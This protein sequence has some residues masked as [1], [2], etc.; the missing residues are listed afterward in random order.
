MLPPTPTNP[1]H[2]FPAPARCDTDQ[3]HSKEK[4]Q[5]TAASRPIKTSDKEK[6]T[7]STTAQPHQHQLRGR[8]PF[9]GDIMARR[10]AAIAALLLVAFVGAASARA[11]NDEATFGRGLLQ[12][13]D[14]TKVHKAC[15]TC[16]NQ[17]IPGTKQTE[18]VCS[19]CAAGWRLRADGTGKKCG[20][21]RLFFLSCCFLCVCVFVCLCVRARPAPPAAYK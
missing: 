21:F 2:T 4:Q 11:L 5:S 12:T 18:L 9:K 14:C 19:T 20:E 6:Q 3:S 16:R 8:R 7:N 17:R 15:S 10:S 1:P 13:L